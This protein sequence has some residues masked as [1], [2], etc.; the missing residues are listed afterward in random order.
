MFQRCKTANTPQYK[1]YVLKAT[2]FPLRIN[3]LIAVHILERLRCLR[4]SDIRTL[5]SADK[6]INKIDSSLNMFHTS[7]QSMCVEKWGENKQ[8]G[9]PRQKSHRQH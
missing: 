8:N 7:G 4:K 5:K 6:Q 1:Y 3:L 9:T 2:V